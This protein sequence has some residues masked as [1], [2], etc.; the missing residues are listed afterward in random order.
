MRKRAPGVATEVT[1]SGGLAALP[2]PLLLAQKPGSLRL[3]DFLA[4]RRGG[5]CVAEVGS[6][7]GRVGPRR[8]G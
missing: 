4:K 7:H 6:E 1:V 2:S 3:A 5:T 8:R